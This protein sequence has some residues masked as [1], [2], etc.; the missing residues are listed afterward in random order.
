MAVIT[1][2]AP[3][4]RKNH[5]TAKRTSQRTTVLKMRFAT[6]LLSRLLG[7]ELLARHAVAALAP[8]IFADGGLEVRL[9]EVRPEDAREDELGIGGLHEEEIA[10]ARLARGA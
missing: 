4:V 1:I 10:H 3:T 7:I 6:A 9:G 8:R 5:S 2:T